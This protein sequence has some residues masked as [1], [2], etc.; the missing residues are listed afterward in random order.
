MPAKIIV[1]IVFFLIILAFMIFG[2]LR[3][4]SRSLK[5]GVFLPIILL[6]VLLSSWLLPTMKTS[7][8]GFSIRNSIEK[9]ISKKNKPIMNVEMFKEK[10]S[11]RVMLNLPDSLKHGKTN[12][13][14][15]DSYDDPKVK[16]GIDKF[17]PVANKHLTQQPITIK[18]IF[19]TEIML[20]ILNVILHLF[21][22]IVL[23]LVFIGIRLGTKN[24]HNSDIVAEA[25]LD[26]IL[27]LIMSAVL[28]FIFMLF[29]LSMIRLFADK[30]DFAFVNAAKESAVVGKLYISNP[31]GKVFDKPSFGILSLLKKLL[32]QAPASSRIL[33]LL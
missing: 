30:S 16:A 17:M 19:A 31:V 24:W 10:D 9:N 18:R 12:P 15:L 26:R 33:F 13:V 20:H 7:Y 27:G 6:S 25:V 23:T 11:G 4:F 2:S 1:D 14:A 5:W 3:G 29:I 32:E 21:F 22:L 8:M 28:I